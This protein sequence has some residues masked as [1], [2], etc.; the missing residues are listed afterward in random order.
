[1]QVEIDRRLYLDAGLEG[2]GPGVAQMQAL[3]TDLAEAL[4]KEV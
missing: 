3:V 2:P 4:K 1:M